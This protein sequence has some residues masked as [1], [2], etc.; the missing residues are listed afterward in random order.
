MKLKELLEMS[1]EEMDEALQELRIDDPGVSFSTQ[2]VANFEIDGM[3]Y[4]CDFFESITGDGKR[5]VEVKFYLLNNPKSPK[6]SDFKTDRQYQIALKKSQLGIAGTGNAF[7]VLSAVCT[8]IKKYIENNTPDYI[9]F[10]ADEENRQK[11]YEAIL[12]WASKYISGYNRVNY[13]PLSGVESGP[14]EFWLE[15]TI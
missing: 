1:S 7:K 11:L 4:K 2:Q 13:N 10:T 6:R 3:K 15:K 14:E 5:I 12:R 9:S 8:A